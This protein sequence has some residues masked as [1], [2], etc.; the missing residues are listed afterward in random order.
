MDNPIVLV[1]VIIVG[2][3]ALG[4]AIW[5]FFRW[6]YVKRLRDLGWEFNTA[7]G[8]WHVVGLNHAP[9]GAGFGREVDDLISGT[10]PN[11]I[12]FKAIEY[13]YK[14]W[15]SNHYVLF[16]PLP[17]ALPF[18]YVRPLNRESRIPGK[19]NGAV[20]QFGGHEVIAGGEEYARTIGQAIVGN[21]GPLAAFEISVDHANLVVFDVAE[22]VED[23]QVA[24][25]AG[26]QIAMA[27]A[28]ACGPYSAPPAPDHLS[29]NHRPNWTYIPRD[30]SYLA[31]IRHTRGGYDHEASDIVFGERDNISFLRLT[32][33]WKT[34]SRDSDGDRTVEYHE[35]F[36][37]E[38]WTK[39]NFA[40][41]K[42]GTGIFGFRNDKAGI[43]F[44]LTEFNKAYK[45]TA[46]DPRFAYDVLHQ[47]MMGW[48]LEVGAPKFEINERGNVVVQGYNK[49]TI[50][51]IERA[52][53]LLHDFF[54]RVPD[55]VWQNLG[56]WPRP[57]PRHE[58]V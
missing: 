56:A 44:E 16:F 31:R 4:F 43:Q 40:P 1:I 10:A 8:I 54:A 46:A 14:G 6:R 33:E 29:F 28:N 58:W 5:G 35:E 18:L 20:C 27:V 25:N 57:V 11:G 34:E 12:N 2:L 52:N 49:W 24:V 22:K 39:F 45:V 17:K 32:H 50:D 48:L 51:D 3:V 21:L 19:P 47:R 15:G 7:P 37:C 13:D 36:L 41:L 23:L 55:V 30:D 9:F 42:L 53:A 26:S 38:F